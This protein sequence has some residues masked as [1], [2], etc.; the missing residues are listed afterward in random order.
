VLGAAR[1]RILLNLDRSSAG[2]LARRTG[3]SPATVTYHC[4]VL[5]AAGLLRRERRG[6]Q[7]LV[8]RTPRGRELVALLSG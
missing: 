3:C 2:A 7:V 6:K 1:A 4:N 5:E 8:S